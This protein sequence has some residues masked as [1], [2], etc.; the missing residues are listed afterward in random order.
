MVAKHRG[1]W[2]GMSLVIVL[3]AGCDPDLAGSGNIIEEERQTPDFVE[4]EL[5]DGI[6]ATIVVD[7]TQ[8][9]KVR[10]IGDDN[11]VEELRTEVVNGDSTLRIHF[12]TEEVGDWISDHPLRAEVTVPTLK[13]LSAAS[14]SEVDLSGTLTSTTFS[15]EASGGTR[16]RARGLDMEALELEV[17]GGAEVTLQGYAHDVTSTLSGG[18]KL[19]ARQLSSREASMTASGGSTIEQQVSDYLSVTASGGSQ[20][21]IIGRPTV[22]AENLSGGSSLRFE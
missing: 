22:R 7:P 9:R 17:S 13:A 20:V 1:H 2:L 12:P 21:A 19:L 11:L 10:L 14:G 6:T 15:L 5:D 8:P 16:V 4:L 18:S 3:L